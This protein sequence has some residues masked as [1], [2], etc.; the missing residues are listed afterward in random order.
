MPLHVIC[1]GCLKR[2]QVGDRFAGMQGP[3]PNCG[4]IIDI[5]RES[6]KMQGDDDA[7]WTKKEKRKAALRPISHIG[8]EFDPVKTRYYA[9]GV[10]GVLLL[11]FLLGC[12]PM[13]AALRSFLGIL[14]LCPIVFPLVLFGYQTLRDREQMFAFSGEELYR[15]AGIVAA[16]YVILWCLFEYFLAAMPADV[17][18]SWLYL[19]AFVVLAVLL[20]HLILAMK[21][22]NAFLHYCLFGFSVIL[23]RF[24]IGLGWFWESNGLIRYST[25]PPPPFLPGM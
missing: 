8:I 21:T 5:P 16:G 9:L 12:I 17:F 22:W 13:Y 18:V 15:R 23:L 19:S 4:T 24:L 6:V 14:G 3:C 10:L 1:S 2:F 25:A 11:T 7:E 20:V